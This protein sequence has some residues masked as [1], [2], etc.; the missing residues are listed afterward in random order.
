MLRC[1]LSFVW[2]AAAKQRGVPLGVTGAERA[3]RF[4]AEAQARANELSPIVRDL[5]K[6]GL[7][8]RAIAAELSKR[9]VPTPH[10]GTWH[11]QL[12]ARSWTA[13][14]GP[15]IAMPAVQNLVGVALDNGIPNA[16]SRRSHCTTN[17]SGTPSV[18]K[19]D[20]RDHL[21]DWAGRDPSAFRLRA[22]SPLIADRTPTANN[23][24]PTDF[25]F[26][27]RAL[28]TNASDRERYTAAWRC[29]IARAHTTCRRPAAI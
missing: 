22:R 2:L 6:Q 27:A 7:S 25:N 4:K 24:T 28:L 9:G 19:H 17:P 16:S 23:G 11:P 1:C 21:H 5:K 15:L 20:R 13:R 8:L 29:C 14:S 26:R 3:K 12:V 18:E 10:G